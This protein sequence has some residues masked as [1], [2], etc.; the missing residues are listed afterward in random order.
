MEKPEEQE[1][2]VKYNQVTTLESLCVKCFKKGET[3][4]LITKIPFF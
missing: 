3:K 2:E 1:I 4:I